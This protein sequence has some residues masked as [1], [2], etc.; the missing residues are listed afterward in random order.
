MR[1]T[2]YRYSRRTCFIYN[3]NNELIGKIQ[4]QRDPH[5]KRWKIQYLSDSLPI[6]SYD[7][8]CDVKEKLVEL[9]LTW[10]WGDIKHY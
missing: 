4:F 8:P 9:D 1:D 3:A 6:H 10:A 2:N 7:R 5:F